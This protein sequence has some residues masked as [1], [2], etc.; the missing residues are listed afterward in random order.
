MSADRFCPS[1]GFHLQAAKVAPVTTE[2]R[3][4]PRFEV[5][6]AVAAD[7][8]NV[9]VAAIM[10]ASRD[11]S[12]ARARKVIA[13]V[14]RRDFRLSYPEIGILLGR[15]HTTAIHAVRAVEAS[16]SLLEDVAAVRAASEVDH[17]AE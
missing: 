2:R 13:Y 8:C 7:R 12:V 15:D 14:L 17:A 11:T 3:T 16:A 6:F 9:R 1:C 5:L 4:L 10:S